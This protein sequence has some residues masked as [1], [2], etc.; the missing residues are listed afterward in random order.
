M[1][2]L[3][4]F[5]LTEPATRRPLLPVGF[6]TALQCLRLDW[7]F[8]SALKEVAFPLCNDFTIG[9]VHLERC[10][11]NNKATRGI[12]FF[13]KYLSLHSSRIRRMC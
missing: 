12:L 7:V 6:I 11:G 3:L 9:K 10:L 4:F 1:Q 2:Y 13:L 8:K 5:Q